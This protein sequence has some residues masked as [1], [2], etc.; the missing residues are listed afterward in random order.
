MENDLWINKYRPTQISQIVGNKIQIDQFLNWLNNINISKK[1]TVIIS[2][3]QGIG[4]T[5]IIKL[6]LEEN[7][8]NV[9]IINPNEIKDHRLYDDFNDYH[10]FSNSIYSKI[11]F[12]KNNFNKIAL[13]FDETENITLTN[14]KKYILDI[15]KENN[16]SKNFPLIFI[17]NNRHSKLLYDLKKGCTEIIFTRPSYDELKPL[18]IDIYNKEG[19]KLE[20]YDSLINKIIQFSQFD[21]RRLINLLQELSFHLKDNNIL[22]ETDINSFIEKSREKNI[23]IGLF[24]STEKVLNNYLDYET[25][26][27]L[28]ENEKVLLPLM[29]HENYFKK[30]L[31]QTSLPFDEI[32][33]IMIKVSD[34]ISKGDNVETSIYTDQ[35]WYLQNIHGF[36]TCINTSFWINKN[37]SHDLLYDDIK[38]SSDLNKTSLKNINKKNIMNLSKLIN[39]KTNQ[40]ILMLNKICNHLIKKHNDY[41]LINILNKYNKNIGIKEIELYLKIDKTTEFNVLESKEKKRLLKHIK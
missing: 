39:N 9:R 10:N 21:I 18:I 37:N 33:N 36:Y 34:S 22:Y 30:I 23:D 35:N 5:L 25:L 12:N 13:I 17:S 28:Y 38:F 14:E 1:L 20:N 7:G 8:Y 3:Y 41:I 2:G 40:E 32:M 24:E 26:I 19:I 6:V 31:K 15:Y 27:K 29:I 4:K 11:S 16:K